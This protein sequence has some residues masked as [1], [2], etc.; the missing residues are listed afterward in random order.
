LNR[1]MGVITTFFLGGLI[2]LFAFSWFKEAA[3]EIFKKD[4]E[5][6]DA[7]TNHRFYLLKIFFFDWVIS[8]IGVVLTGILF[9]VIFNIFQ[10]L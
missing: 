5:S 3:T 6:A 4:L 2:F 9:L 7:S 10:Y 8:V 1:E